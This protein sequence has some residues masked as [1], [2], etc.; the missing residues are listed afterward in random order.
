MEKVKENLDY[1]EFGGD[2]EIDAIIKDGKLILKLKKL[3]YI[4]TR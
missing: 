1:L 2:K 4:L 3:F